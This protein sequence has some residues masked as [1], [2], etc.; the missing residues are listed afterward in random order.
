MIEIELSLLGAFN[1][2]V[3]FSATI[4]AHIRGTFRAFSSR[5]SFL[6][7]EAAGSLE[8]PGL[9]AIRLGMA[10]FEVVGLV[11]WSENNIGSNIGPDSPFLTAVEAWTH[12]ARLGAISFAVAVVREHCQ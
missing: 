11:N 10:I 4:L 5:M 7:A 3:T 1:G 6:F 12:L 9:G 8:N 2:P